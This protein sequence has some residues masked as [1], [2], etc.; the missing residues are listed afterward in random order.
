MLDTLQLNPNAGDQLARRLWPKD[1]KKQGFE[2]VFRYE[3]DNAMRAT[4]TV[5]RLDNQRRE[6]RIIDFFR[7]H[8]EYDR[9]F[10]Y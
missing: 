5:R 7:T 10:H 8:K 1:Y 9:K 4:Y 6:V 2:S 3:I